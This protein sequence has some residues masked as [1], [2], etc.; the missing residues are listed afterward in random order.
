VASPVTGSCQRAGGS[1]SSASR[2]DTNSS[3]PSRWNTGPFSPLSDRVSRRAWVA[4]DGSISHKA[5]TNLL[6]SLFS[7]DTAA[8]SRRPS[9]DRV[10]PVT[11]GRARYSSNA[12]NPVIPAP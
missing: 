5:L 4:P 3:E 6:P 7:A 12:S 8:T 10:N 1:S 11:R 9:A 2:P